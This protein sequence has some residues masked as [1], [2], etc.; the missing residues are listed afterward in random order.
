[1]A[2]L[3]AEEVEPRLAVYLVKRMGD[4]GFGLTQLQPD[5]REPLLDQITTVLDHA[6]V[7]VQHYQVI[8]VDNNLGLPVEQTPR[9]FRVVPCLSW[10]LAPDMRFES[11]Q[12]NV[13][14]K[15]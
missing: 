14:Q 12:S 13:G 5:T 1:M 3:E 10:K 9:L 6:S 7:P 15:R 4:A 8:G 2:N 11:V